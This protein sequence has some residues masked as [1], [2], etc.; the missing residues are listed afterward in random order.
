[1]DTITIAKDYKKN[2]LGSHKHATWPLYPADL[3]CGPA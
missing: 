2:Q 1:M 3:E